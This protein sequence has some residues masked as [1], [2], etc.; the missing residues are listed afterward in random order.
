MLEINTRDIVNLETYTGN[1][2]ADGPFIY[3]GFKP[4][5]VMIKR[6]L[7]ELS[8]EKWIMMDHQRTSG[9]NTGNP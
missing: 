6:I 8:G 2:N 5:F 9:F 7:L 3:T 4:A 1:G